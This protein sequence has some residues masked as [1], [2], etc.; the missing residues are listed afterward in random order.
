MNI[1]KQLG[2]KIKRLRK[3]K[4]LTQ[5]QLAEIIEIA[6]RNLCNIELGIN[7]VKADT[8][9]K[10]L[11]ALDTTTEEMFS[12]EHLRESDELIDEINELI[13]GVKNDRLK[14]EKISKVIKTLAKD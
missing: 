7:F 10:I 6:P 14:L 5:E 3:K 13:S 4:N 8:L 9:E 2:E 11:I 1:K 12:N